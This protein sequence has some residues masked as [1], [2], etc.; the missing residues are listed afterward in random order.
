MKHAARP[1]VGL[2]WIVCWPLTMVFA[3][4]VFLAAEEIHRTS[5]EA[6][7]PI[8]GPNW[9][10]HLRQ[11]VEAVTAALLSLP[12]KLPRPVEQEKGSGPLRWTHRHFDLTISRAEQSQAESAIEAL[13]DVD[14]GVTI[15]SEATFNGV[16]VLIGLDGLLTHTLR[17]HW[18]DRPAK[19]R[20]GVVIDSLGEDLRIA[21]EVVQLGAPVALGVIPFRPFSR[22]VAK[23]GRQFERDVLLHLPERIGDDTESDATGGFEAA[24]ATVPDAIG[25]VSGSGD[26]R[27]GMGPDEPMIAE[28][29]RRGLFCLGGSEAVAADVGR[30]IPG[31]LVQARVVSLDSDARPADVTR[32]LVAL[33]SAAREDG[34]AIGIGRADDATITAL[35]KALL[36][37]QTAEI[38]VVSLSELATGKNLSTY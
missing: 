8:G 23:L 34:V 31:F 37:W 17:F 29:K 3:A 16:E 21:R 30:G 20:V 22:E 36:D 6:L 28:L 19:P 26:D 14:R 13:R 18:K 38:E 27:P 33:T 24:L 2:V 15:T 5:R 12:L 11:R 7:Q 35:R 25:V 9:E 10:A 32:W 1:P 4:M